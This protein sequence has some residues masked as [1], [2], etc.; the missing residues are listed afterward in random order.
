MQ[1][2]QILNHTK[3]ECKYHPSLSSSQKRFET[4]LYSIITKKSSISHVMIR[5]Q[6]KFISKSAAEILFPY[7]SGTWGPKS[8][9]DLKSKECTIHELE[10]FAKNCRYS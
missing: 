10:N 7:D 2:G 1:I 9:D 5:H 8:V 3:R 6:T 4:L